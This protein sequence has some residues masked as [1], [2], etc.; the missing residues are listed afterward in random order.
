[1]KVTMTSMLTGKTR[2]RDLD[3]TQKQIDAWKGGKLIQDVMPDIN[4][5]DREFLITGAVAEEWA[6]AFPEDL[7][8]GI[9]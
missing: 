3:I 5:S 1:M 6:E 2:T 8:E 7:I 9:V 4:E